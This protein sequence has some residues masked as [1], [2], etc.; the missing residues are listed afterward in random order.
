MG[1]TTASRWAHPITWDRRRT[2]AVIIRSL[3]IV[4][5]AQMQPSFS[6]SQ[7]T[8]VQ[9]GVDIMVG[10]CVAGGTT[11]FSVTAD[12]QQDFLVKDIQTD[13]VTI[14]VKHSE[15]KG[16]VGGINNALTQIAATEADKVRKCLEPVRERVL[17]ILFPSRKKA[18]N[19][20]EG[21]PNPEGTTSP[22]YNEHNPNPEVDLIALSDLGRTR[23]EIRKLYPKGT[24]V[25]DHRVMKHKHNDS[26][27]F[28]RIGSSNMMTEISNFL[29]NKG[30]V[31]KTEF[32]M[33]GCSADGDI[34]T[35]LIDA[36]GSPVDWRSAPS[37]TSEPTYEFRANQFRVI[38][39]SNGCYQDIAVFEETEIEN[40]PLTWA[41][42][43]GW[44]YTGDNSGPI[45]LAMSIVGRNTQTSEVH[46]AG[47]YI[48]SDMTGET[49]LAEVDGRLIT[50]QTSPIPPGATVALWI[51]LPGTMHEKELLQKWGR[52]YLYVELDGRRYRRFYSEEYMRQELN[53]FSNP[54]RNQDVTRKTD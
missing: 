9:T 53:H 6:F 25:I 37:L 24:I 3:L 5:A 42:H 34:L 12:P 49:R 26:A 10:L 19:V 15:W 2:I 39:T 16:L 40:G 44:R 47:A 20:A 31:I 48:V 54:D 51:D 11:T 28:V 18:A 30:K 7:S 50:R 46:L 22:D 14:T 13:K 17:E 35:F 38:W 33:L 36:Y 4:L 41:G 32:H 27:N 1:T 23:P 52:M 8:D 29:D 43:F 45:F 21:V